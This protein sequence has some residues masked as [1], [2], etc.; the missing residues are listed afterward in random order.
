MG[1]RERDTSQLQCPQ[2]ASSTDLCCVVLWWVSC[3]ALVTVVADQNYRASVIE[4]FSV[5]AFT[6]SKEVQWFILKCL[7]RE[8]KAFHKAAWYISFEEADFFSP[9]SVQ[10]CQ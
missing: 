10:L 2:E 8:C 6:S 9:P 7:R 1:G 3:T 4:A 5:R